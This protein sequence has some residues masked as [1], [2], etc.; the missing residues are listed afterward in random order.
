MARSILKKIPSGTYTSSEISAALGI[1]ETARAQ[2]QT[3]TP[4]FKEEA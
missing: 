1:R 4:K 3:P 2:H